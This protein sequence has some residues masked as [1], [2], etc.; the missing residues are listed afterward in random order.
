MIFAYRF[1]A[2]CTTARVDEEALGKQ[3]FESE[4][5]VSPLHE[6]YAVRRAAFYMLCECTART[7]TALVHRLKIEVN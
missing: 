1:I 3:V 4:A 5:E 7:I 6:Q 2:H